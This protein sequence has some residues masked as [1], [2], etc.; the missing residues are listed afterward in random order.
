PPGELRPTLRCRERRAGDRPVGV[1]G[2]PGPDPAGVLAAG[3]AAAGPPGLPVR[4]RRV[5]GGGLGAASAGEARRR[6]GGR[7][8]AVQAHVGGRLMTDRTENS[9]SGKKAPRSCNLPG[10]DETD[11]LIKGL[12]SDQPDGH[13]WTHR[14]LADPD[15]APEP[16]EPGP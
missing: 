12:C 9:V 16:A 4:G 5:A 6:R 3:V 13:W 1:V 15:P 14:G 2:D 7:R 10:C 11:G 8:A